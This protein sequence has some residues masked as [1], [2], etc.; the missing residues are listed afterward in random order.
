MAKKS[1]IILA[2]L[3]L[4]FI[5][6]CANQLPPSGGVIDKIPPEII[7]SIPPN[8][9]INFLGN[10]IELSFSEY[11]DKR[12]VQDAIFISPSID[13]ELEYDWSGKTLEIVFPNKLKENTTYTITIGTD[14]VDINNRNNMAHSFTLSF[15]TGDVI[16]K[17]IAKGK[18]YD[19]NPLGTLI[20]AYK[21][22]NDSIPDLFKTK[23]DYISQVG[24]SGTFE[25]MGL[26]KAKYFF[27]AI[28]D[29]LRN[30]L[31]D[32]GID[33]VG[34]P[35]S[36]YEINS[37]DTLIS[38]INFFISV[39]DTIPPSISNVAMIDRNHLL[40]DFNEPIDSAK[41]SHSNFFIVD[42][43]S[44]RTYQ[45][46]AFF[47]NRN[48]QYYLSIK[49]SL[50]KDGNNFLFSN[51]LVD[52]SGNIS[53]IESS[54]II[55]NEKPDT[56]KPK[57]KSISTEYEK[58][59]VDFVNPYFIIQFDDGIYSNNLKGIFSIK[60]IPSS[61][62]YFDYSMIDGALMK[63]NYAGRLNPK[64]SYTLLIDT[65]RVSDIAGN[66]MDSLHTFKFTTNNELDF[67]GVSGSVVPSD[68]TKVVVTLKSLSAS[69]NSLSQSFNSSIFNFT[70]VKPGKYLLW[71][72]EDKDSSNTY[73]KGKLKPFQ[74]AEKF[75]FYSDTLNVRP[76]WPIG[77]INLDLN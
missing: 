27:I 50:K 72:Y 10:S 16:D 38:D 11:V 30:Q 1:K 77:D 51:A 23:P 60:E 20:Y 34:L 73:S 35:S 76:R 39:D 43:T 59:T 37:V 36:L 48:Q 52:F 7:E 21:M 75:K 9:T 65:K 70:K 71:I 33:A 54:S 18:V 13:D 8:G 31:Y 56:T 15:S 63:L 55:L 25:L 41:I 12:S 62:T 58:N 46:A 45:F 5:Y 17:N 26:A 4:S 67:G 2:V 32:K 66:K 6:G 28:K 24:K 47:K 49:D 53:S 40:L 44:N 64:S 29:E 69:N 68:K 3:V 61:D 42:S 14:V 74:P 19:R 22:Q 57:I